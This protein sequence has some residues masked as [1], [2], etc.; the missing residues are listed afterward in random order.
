M[1][2]KLP[3]GEVTTE[4]A[5]LSFNPTFY[6]APYQSF[7]GNSGWTTFSASWVAIKAT[8]SHSKSSPREPKTTP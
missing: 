5:R 3:L 8:S 2:A 6:N 7:M 4:Q 1:T